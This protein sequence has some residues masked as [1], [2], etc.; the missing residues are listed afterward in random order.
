ML[1]VVQH[2]EEE[3][4]SVGSNKDTFIGSGPSANAPPLQTPTKS[5]NFGSTNLVNIPTS[6]MNS[7]INNKN[8][9][10]LKNII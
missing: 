10:T 9:I 8:M 7:S 6:I 1:N 4:K 3:L 5:L 2:Q